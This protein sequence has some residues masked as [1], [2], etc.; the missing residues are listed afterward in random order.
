MTMPDSA[1]AGKLRQ[2][3]AR[4]GDDHEA[5]GFMTD[6]EHDEVELILLREAKRVDGAL[7]DHPDKLPHSGRFSN[8]E[9]AAAISYASDRMRTVAPDE[10]QHGAFTKHLV[11]LLK[12]QARRALTAGDAH[13]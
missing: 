5:C 11:V 10:A 13:T 8:S 4:I 9:L 6:D 2:L 1:W 12:I 3:A 7:E